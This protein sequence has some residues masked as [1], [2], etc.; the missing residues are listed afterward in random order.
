MPGSV[1]DIAEEELVELLAWREALARAEADQR[2][3]QR[4]RSTSEIRRA[5]VAVD[6]TVASA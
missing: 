5:V 4:V 3:L 1:C 6:T 2:T